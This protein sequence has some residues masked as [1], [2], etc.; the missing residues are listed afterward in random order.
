MR[1]YDCLKTSLFLDENLKMIDLAQRDIDAGI[2][3]GIFPARGLKQRILWVYW[4]AHMRRTISLAR[5][6]GHVSLEDYYLLNELWFLVFLR[7]YRPEAKDLKQ[8]RGLP[9]S[10]L[11]SP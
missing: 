2:R 10:D 7:K 9:I 8:A 6:G 4:M 3:E 1:K 5:Q 11:L